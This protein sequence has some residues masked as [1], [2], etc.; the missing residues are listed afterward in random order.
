MQLLKRDR[1]ARI[2]DISK[3]ILPEMVP[4]QL[5]LLGLSVAD[6][7]LGDLNQIQACVAPGIESIK[8]MHARARQI[9][10][11]NCHLYGDRSTTD[12]PSQLQLVIENCDIFMQ[13]ANALSSL[14]PP[15]EPSYEPIYKLI[16]RLVETTLHL[17]YFADSNDSL[18]LTDRYTNTGYDTKVIKPQKG[19]KTKAQKTEKVK[20][21]VNEMARHIYQHD[22]LSN[23]PK[24]LLAEAIQ[25]RLAEFSA[26][27]N[28][29]TLP[30]LMQFVNRTPEYLS[31]MKW[32]KPIKPVKSVN[33][34]KP[35]LARLSNELNAA[36]K[37]QIIT[38]RLNA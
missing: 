5:K 14:I 3:M 27:G 22:D 37:S 29:N 15:E 1:Q 38:Q 4:E 16:D 31:I 2:D 10:E 11:D 8:L 13:Q 9:K 26:E 20:A 12:G 32:L 36:F 33:S 23:T 21:L 35:S 28:N 24:K 30:A 6:I 7:T 25:R 19:G 17:A 34:L 18:A